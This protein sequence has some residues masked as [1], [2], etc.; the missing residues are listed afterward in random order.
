MSKA[1]SE[2]LVVVQGGRSG[3]IQDIMARQHRLTADEP[4]S[5]GGE[6][7]GATPYELL[8]AALGACTSMTVGMYARARNWPLEGVI[9]LNG[10]SCQLELLDQKIELSALSNTQSI[11]FNPYSNN[12]HRFAEIPFRLLP[13]Q[14][15]DEGA[16]PPVPKTGCSNSDGTF[17]IKVA[18]MKLRMICGKDNHSCSLPWAIRSSQF[19]SLGLLSARQQLGAMG[20]IQLHDGFPATRSFRPSSSHSMASP[21]QI[22]RRRKTQ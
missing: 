4:T 16:T 2:L 19:C 12:R 6:D 14:G 9:V 18:C 5:S 7:M 22:T 17:S 15:R 13:S 8:L 11:Q 20:R 1:V 10:P 3:F 21:I